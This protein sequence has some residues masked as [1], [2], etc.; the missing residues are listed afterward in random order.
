M[1]GNTLTG[2]WANTAGAT[3]TGAWKAAA[4]SGYYD[5][6]EP[7]KH[8][9]DPA[10]FQTDTPDPKR[11]DWSMPPVQDPGYVAGGQYP[12]MEWIIATGGM[13]LDQ[14]PDDDHSPPGYGLPDPHTV[15]YG[16][17]AVTVKGDAVLGYPGQTDEAI[18]LEG[19]GET[20]ISPTAINRG[21]NSLDQN[22]PQGFRRGFTDWW[23]SNRP[24]RMI[25][26]ANA[27]R[28]VW[29]NTA[30]VVT[31]VP[32][33]AGGWSNTSSPFDSLARQWKN[34]WVKPQVR[35]EPDGISDGMS[36]DGAAAVLSQTVPNVWVVG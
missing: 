7:K 13:V 17:T 14:T 15:D 8:I 20:A 3:V 35:R 24:S 1:A 5:P 9:A 21:L 27:S 26:R 11:A 23:R 28:P 4:T 16:G 22:N 10:H 30:G 6:E 34:V 32:P 36:G 2:A 33:P 31:N 19:L 25:D 12:G 29:V 18:R